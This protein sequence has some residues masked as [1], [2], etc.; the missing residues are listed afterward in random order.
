M[1]TPI[2]ARA[3]ARR[4]RRAGARVRSRARA[5]AAGHAKRLTMSSAGTGW[6]SRRHPRMPP[7]RACA[8]CWRSTRHIAGARSAVSRLL[9]AEAR[10][11][12]SAGRR[13]EARALAMEAAELTPESRRRGRPLP[14]SPPTQV[15]RIDALRRLVALSPER[16]PLRNQLRRALLA[17]A[18]ID[19]DQRSRR[20]A[21]PVPR[22]RDARS[23]RSAHLAGALQPRRLAR[24]AD[25]VPARAAA[26]RARSSAGPPQ[27]APGADRDARELHA[28]AGRREEARDCWREAIDIAGGDVELWL[29]LAEATTDPDE[30]ARGDPIRLRDRSARRARDRGARI[31]SR[32]RRSIPTTPAVARRRVRALRSADGCAGARVCRR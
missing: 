10:T 16:S 29:G 28:R 1:S 9:I 27:A 20:S 8:A 22:S 23:E 12:A 30:A 31:G 15:E 3:S 17:R 5:A 32:G 6:R 7:S 11:A 21:Q 25:A 4:D 13:D 14:T 26:R 19:R 18:V 24:G 2:A